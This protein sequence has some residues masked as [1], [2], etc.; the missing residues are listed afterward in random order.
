MNFDPKQH[1]EKVYQ[2]KG[3]SQVSWYQTQLGNSLDLIFLSKIGQAGRVIDVGGG[4]S[5]LVDKL[6]EKEF[7][8]ITVLDISAHAMKHARERLG[9]KAEKVTWIEV[10]ITKFEPSQ[11]Y[12]LWHDRAVFHFLTSSEDRKKYIE[13]MKR[14][15]KPGGHVIIASFALDG[16]MKCSGLN[17]ERYSP[18]KLKQEL[19]DSFLFVKSMDE[20]HVTPWQSEQKFMYCY[21]QKKNG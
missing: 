17:V 3:P 19:G 11:Q 21:F 15:V 6:L 4:A 13:T 18:E 10:D 8:D 20:T 2:E 14:A 16:P 1:W 5:I 7:K 9:K 12:D